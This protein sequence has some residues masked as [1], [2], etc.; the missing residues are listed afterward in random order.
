MNK[1]KTKK[2]YIVKNKNKKL[3]GMYE[4]KNE[5]EKN[6]KKQYTIIEVITIKGC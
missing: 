1:C 4:T 5:A 2:Y 3:I 6:T